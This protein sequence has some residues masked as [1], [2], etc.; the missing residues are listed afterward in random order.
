MIINKLS[1]KKIVRVLSETENRK[2]RLT[3]FL[4]KLTTVIIKHLQNCCQ[5]RKKLTNRF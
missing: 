1:I 3:T 5:N 2:N 4:T